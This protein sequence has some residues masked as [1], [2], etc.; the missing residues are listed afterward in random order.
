M[1]LS[2]LPALPVAERPIP[3]TQTGLPL[4]RLAG[5]IARNGVNDPIGGPIEGVL[6]VYND[7]RLRALQKRE[8]VPV[9]PVPD[10]DE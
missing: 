8:G 7:W 4:S 2:D 10:E 5:F 9:S 3:W 6:Y 1:T